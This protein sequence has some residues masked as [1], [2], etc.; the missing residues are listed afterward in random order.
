MASRAISKSSKRR[1]RRSSFRHAL[2][3]LAVAALLIAAVLVIGPSLRSSD[4]IVFIYGAIITWI[5]GT[6]AIFMILRNMAA[7]LERK[8][9]TARAGRA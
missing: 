8:S 2:T 7:Q 1:P 5:V 3:G 4:G 6:I 9:A